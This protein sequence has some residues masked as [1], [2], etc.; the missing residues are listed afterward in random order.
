[1][2]LFI[3]FVSV[4][5]YL[6]LSTGVFK[7]QFKREGRQKHSAVIRE[8]IHVLVFETKIPTEYL[9]NEK[10]LLKKYLLRA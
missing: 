2:L 1:M 7:L 5:R 9:L 4:V 10:Y 6:A 3:I 8:R